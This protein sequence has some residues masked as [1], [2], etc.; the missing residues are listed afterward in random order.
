MIIYI[1][2]TCTYCDG[3]NHITLVC[4]YVLFTLAAVIYLDRNKSVSQ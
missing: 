2:F 3:N 1:P 4:L